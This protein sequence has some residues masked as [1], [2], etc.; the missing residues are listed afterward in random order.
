MIS[1]RDNGR[2]RVGAGMTGKRAIPLSDYPSE[3]DAFGPHQRIAERLFN[4]IRNEKRGHPIALIGPWGS[5]KST[6]IRLLRRRAEGDPQILIFVF[7]AW[8]HEGDP[9]RRAFLESLAEALVEH[10]WIKSEDKEEILKPLRVREQRMRATSQHI[11]TVWGAL[12]SLTLV[13]IT[14]IVIPLSDRPDFPPLTWW[15]R[16]LLFAG[17]PAL[18]ILAALLHSKI[19]K[20]PIDLSIFLQRESEERTESHVIE[21]PDPTSL[22]FQERFDEL[23]KKA[24][25]EDQRRLVLVMDNLDRAAPEEAL[26]L[27]ATMR[28]FLGREDLSSDPSSQWRSHLW[29]LVPFD[30]S[31]I[32][33]LWEGS[34]PDLMRAIRRDVPGDLME[35]FL[36]KT[37]RLRLE[38]PEPA[39]DAWSD[40]FDGMIAEA[41]PEHPPKE[42]H[43]ARGVF[44][45]LIARDPGRRNPLTPRE[46]KGFINEMVAVYLGAPEEEEYPLPHIAAYVGLRRRG[47]APL[48][49]IPME[50][51]LRLWAEEKLEAHLAALH[52]GVP[53]EKALYLLVEPELSRAIQERDWQRIGELAEHPGVPHIMKRILESRIPDWETEDPWMLPLCAI[54]LPRDWGQLR[55]LLLRSI[56]SVQI[57]KSPRP[58]GGEALAGLMSE[59]DVEERRQIMN[60]LIQSPLESDVTLLREVISALDELIRTDPTLAES[61]ILA[62]DP[63]L[64]IRRMALLGRLLKDEP[65]PGAVKNVL[66][67]MR[68]GCSP[69]EVIDRLGGL[70]AQEAPEVNVF[71]ALLALQEV[72]V[73]WPW[74]RLLPPLEAAL[75][76][77]G[78]GQVLMERLFW[79][80][81]LGEKARGADAAL[82]RL[83]QSGWIANCIGRLEQEGD[84][85]GMALA[86]LA[87]LIGSPE[88]PN[89]YPG[90]ASSSGKYRYDQFLQ[91]PYASPDLLNFMIDLAVRLGLAGA[92]L[93]KWG[94]YP[95]SHDVLQRILGSIATVRP[96]LFPI[97]AIAE[98]IR[99][100]PSIFPDP[101]IRRSVLEAGIRNGLMDLLGEERLEQSEISLELL[102]IAP[103]HP[104]WV[105]LALR[106]AGWSRDDWLQA[107][108]APSLPYRLA[109]ELAKRG[110][111]KEAGISLQDALEEKARQC[112]NNQ[113]CPDEETVRILL[114]LLPA[115]RK[116]SL[117]ANLITPMASAME[118]PVPMLRSFRRLLED[119]EA[120]E[121]EAPRMIREIIFRA[122]RSSDPE[123]RRWAL[124]RI[125]ECGSWLERAPLEILQEL[126]ERLHE[127]PQEEVGEEI[128]KRIEEALRRRSANAT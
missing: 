100:L 128:L 124:G 22:E 17:L 54:H 70:L 117:A 31:G 108:A 122:L 8:E 50:K 67:Y 18:I 84:Q 82:Q 111:L 47:W 72:R 30:R 5:G 89:S 115:A 102:E 20:R 48:G 9:L 69:Q 39:L 64:Y 57:W 92:L 99:E 127:L 40:F 76:R 61:L 73:D 13:L 55:D 104:K 12:F 27:W 38:I 21:G 46:I 103:D 49:E 116:R 36:G 123:A 121:E 6:I 74:E 28:L 91:A 90:S 43:A 81:R 42:R 62:D 45:L 80:L 79:L 60:A 24:L 23:C 97:E 51:S 101:S 1:S 53:S 15:S 19:R 85:E 14:L 7:D 93:E 63:S 37:F 77:D 110:I 118:F 98:R 29:L 16:L 52:L 65:R 126:L 4:L 78:S 107:M 88:P 32:A 120:F 68:P 125:L 2:M 105:R 106:Y 114:G 66:P 26:R 94:V 25:G 59:F 56:P 109:I 83:A 41:F 87:Q 96:E 113:P 112:I 75:S 58:G 11:F 33:R 86:I 3:T 35:A 95:R 71:E 119:C 44:D 34:A 10:E